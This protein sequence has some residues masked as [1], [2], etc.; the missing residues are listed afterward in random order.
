MELNFL[1]QKVYLKWDIKSTKQTEI[2]KN[3]IIAFFALSISRKEK[4][5]LAIYITNLRFLLSATAVDIKAESNGKDEN[6]TNCV[7]ND[8]F[9]DKKKRT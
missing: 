7:E 6:V 1:S 5:F 4:Y 3:D 2:Y 9:K 8:E